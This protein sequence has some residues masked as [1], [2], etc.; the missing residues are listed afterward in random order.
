MLHRLRARLVFPKSSGMAQWC[1]DQMTVRYDQAVHVN[2][3]AANEESKYNIVQ[4]YDADND[5]FKCDLP[6]MDEAHAIDAYNTLSDASVWAWLA[7]GVGVNWVEHHTCD[8]DEVVRSGC[9]TQ[10]RKTY[11]E[12]LE[13]I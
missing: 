4:E 9:V 2:E 8:H 12:P 1:Y 7:D 6:L 5:E 3:G 11:G 13:D 10:S